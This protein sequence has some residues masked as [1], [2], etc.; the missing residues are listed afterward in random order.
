TLQQTQRLLGIVGSPAPLRINGPERHMRK[1][2]YRRAA[3]KS[4]DVFAEPV[5]LRRAKRSEPAGFEI[6]HV[7]ETD[8]MDA[9]VVEAVPSA[10]LCVP[11]VTSEVRSSVV[12]CDVVLARHVEDPI[13]P[14]AFQYFVGGIEFFGFGELSDVASVKNESRSLRQ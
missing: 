12:G 13:G 11:S 3:R 6:E 10:A 1:K 8:E 2:H 5:D 9:G 4:G 7:D 14:Y